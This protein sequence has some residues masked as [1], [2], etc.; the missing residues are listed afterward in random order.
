MQDLT[1]KKF[2]RLTVIER[3]GR[4]KE[5]RA[6]WLCKC[7]CGKTKLV[8]TKDLTTHRVRSC[9]C[10]AFEH[11]SKM[12]KQSGTHY[13]RKTRLYTIWANM[14]Q[15]CTNTNL[16]SFKDYGGRGIIICDEW[17]N[18][19]VYFY[20][21]A[22]NNGYSDKLTI[23]RIDVNGNYEPSNCRWSTY[24]EQRHNRRDTILKRKEGSISEI[25]Q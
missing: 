2:D 11:N 18:N 12:G 16:K 22:I 23:D 14:K 19:F 10:L 6:L 24:L 25:V 20:D 21:W 15:R 3:K 1:G 7:E 5:N 9:G 17:L 4:T 13:K 8:S